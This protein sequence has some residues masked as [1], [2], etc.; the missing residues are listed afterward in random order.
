MDIEGLSDIIVQTVREPMLVLDAELRV[1]LA[2]HSFYST[3]LVTPEQTLG[4]LIYELGNRQWDIAALR[5]LLDDF[6]STDGNFEDYLVEHDFP[7]IGRRAI[8][9]NARRLHDGDDTTKLILL[10]FEDVTERR[11][12]E[13]QFQ[14]SDER[15]RMALDSAQLGTWH[16]HPST[17]AFTCDQRFRDIFGV[18]DAQWLDYEPVIAI[19]HPDDQSRVRE[20]VA[21]ATRPDNPVRYDIEYRIVHPNGSIR[22]VHAKGRAN[23]TDASQSEIK[24]VSFDGTVGDI[25]ERKRAEL[26]IQCQKQS[27]ELLVKGEP[28]EQVLDFLAR[29]MES[30]S[31]GKF[32]VAIHLMESDGYHF[33]YVAAPSLPASYALATKG[34]DA[35][36]N[37]GACSSA[38]MAREPTVVR[39]FVA[40]KRWPAFTA[41][42]I[43]LGLRGCFTTPIVSSQGDQK[44]L[45]TFAIY[46]R[47]PR[48]PSP[49]DRQLVDLVTHTVALAIDRKQAEHALRLAEKGVRA[50]EI[51][52]RRLFESAH[53]GI[54]ILDLKTRLITDVNPFLLELL[55]YPRAHFIG[56]ELWEIGVFRDKDQSQA[57]MREVYENAS[58]RFENMPLQDRNGRLHAVEIVANMY[59]EDHHPV[60]QCNI[61]DIGERVRFEKERAALLAN[62]Q[63]SRLEAEAA[64]R[65]KDM[66]LATLSH[67]LRTPLTAI[68]GW[69]VLLR[70]APTNE[71]VVKEAA[72][73]IERNAKM[74]AQLIEDVLDVSRIV[75]GKLRL[76][77][78]SSELSRIIEDAVASVQPAAD[79][80]NIHIGVKVIP[81]ASPLVCDAGRI[82]QV[83]WNLLTNAIKFSPKFGHIRVLVERAN[84]MARITIQDSGEGISPEFLPHVFERFRQSD[85]TSTRKHGGLGLGL[86]IVLHLVELHGGTIDVQSDGPGQGATFIINLPIRALIDDEAASDGTASRGGLVVPDAAVAGGP[87]IVRLNGLRVLV[88]D[89]EPDARNV[90]KAALEHAGATVAVA[91]SASAALKL[92]ADV[93]PH[94]IVSDISMPVQDGYELMKQIRSMGVGYSGRDLPAVALTAYARTEDRRR[95]LLA[96]FQMHVAKPVDPNELAEVV[97]SLAG[98]TGLS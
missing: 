7:D 81:G 42:V 92:L 54:L 23:F 56:K 71:K 44:I 55:D 86:S 87:A 36:L 78:R 41:E 4:K 15:G 60:I 69:A 66:F 18:P 20:A 38:V 57:A 3:F 91:D 13:R 24:L 89:D 27:L 95:A 96:G 2:N 85:G 84:S 46:Y 77:M 10:V 37:L 6:L 12:A 40:E 64:N 67:E 48:D 28:I 68:L 39:D 35:R 49:H 22:W 53:D 43:S 33:G 76:E 26:L 70:S 47:E 1:Q 75:S 82:Q 25:T 5:K 90:I 34:M 51:R 32:L 21:A 73:T 79:A 19:M 9:L 14:A 58:I 88:A 30:Q 80:K 8:L 52:Y 50:S 98:R 16:V 17:K 74:Q 45:G 63:T 72:L 83:I 65:A 11:R 59:E 29:S 97:A 94:V 61:R 62:E 93:H 31:Q